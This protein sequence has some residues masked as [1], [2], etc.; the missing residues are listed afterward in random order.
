MKDILLCFVINYIYEI[1]KILPDLTFVK[2]VVRLVVA[3]MMD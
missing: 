1:H 3:R 2:N